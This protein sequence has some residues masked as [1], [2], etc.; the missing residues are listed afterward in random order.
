M[1]LYIFDTDHITL[2]FSQA[3]FDRFAELRW[4]PVRIGSQDLRIAA[5][6]LAIGAILVIR[7]KRDFDQVPGLVSED[8]SI[9]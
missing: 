1:S 4:Q 3:P 2:E 9:G 6:A 8:W 7:N 5:I